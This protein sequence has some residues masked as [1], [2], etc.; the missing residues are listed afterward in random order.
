[1][2]AIHR[3]VRSGHVHRWRLLI[4]G[5]Q[6]NCQRQ[7]MSSA[8]PL[9]LHTS[10]PN[11]RSVKDGSGQLNNLATVKDRSPSPVFGHWLRARGSKHQRP[12]PNPDH[13][14]RTVLIWVIISDIRESRSCLMRDKRRVPSS[15][16]PQPH[17]GRSHWI[18]KQ[19]VSVT[20]RAQAKKK[21]SACLLEPHHPT[22]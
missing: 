2:V 4:D 12:L 20:N 14:A 8:T 13:S 17:V 5:H 9:V 22:Y 16:N 7:T 3:R 11:A 1:M 19:Q 18:T 15:R 6:A 10:S 21:D